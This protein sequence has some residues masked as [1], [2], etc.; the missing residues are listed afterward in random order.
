[1]EKSISELVFFM[2]KYIPHRIQFV[3][4]NSAGNLQFANENMKIHGTIPRGI[5]CGLAGNSFENVDLH[6]CNTHPFTHFSNSI[7]YKF[8]SLAEDD[9]LIA[10]V[11]GIFIL[12][13][14]INDAC[15]PT[16]VQQKLPE[17]KANI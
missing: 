2:I 11:Y 10:P 16:L 1:M 9:N 6:S 7:T 8:R 14:E 12:F 4:S 3:R 13:S 17:T 5:Y 15:V